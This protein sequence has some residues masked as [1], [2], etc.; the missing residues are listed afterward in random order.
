VE[1][2]DRVRISLC[3][4]ALEFGGINAVVHALATG[5]DP[6][7][8]AVSVFA[9]GPNLGAGDAYRLAGVPVY[10]AA[11]DGRAEAVRVTARLWRFLRRSRIE[12]VHAHPGSLSRLTALLAGVPVV[13][14]TYHGS[15]TEGVGRAELRFRRFLDSRAT[16]I[17]A[18]S[19]ATRDHVVHDIRLAA[20][21]IRVIYN[22]V[23]LTR[24]RPPSPAE[25][26]AARAALGLG[27]DELV[28]GTVARLYADKGV[29]DIVTALAT[30]RASGI[31][32]HALVV[33]DGPE[34][35][36]LQR[37][38]ASLKLSPFVR[39]LGSRTDVP[40]VLAACDLAVLA[41]RTR[42]GFGIALAEAMAMALPVVGTTIE[43][44]PEVIEAGRTGVLVP[45]GDPAAL[46]DALVSLARSPERR[47]ELGSCGRSAVEARF[48]RRRMVAEYSALYDELLDHRRRPNQDRG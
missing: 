41:S 13:V 29:A 46:H 5:L 47:R 23:D 15:W 10:A 24:F 34:R 43:G 36:S 7:R 22:G 18:N 32:V 17:V 26:Q 39:F 35:P 21:R 28:V 14:S 31:P 16:A 33:G 48:D 9:L 27:P 2:S 4:S 6:E 12:I 38:A 25:R 45:P 37:Q 42:E 3:V 20:D 30:V 11:G 8:F 44:I 40:D 19:C 1:R